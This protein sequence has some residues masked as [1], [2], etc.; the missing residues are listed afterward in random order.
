M[1]PIL[2]AILLVPAV[3]GEVCA[4]T[5]PPASAVASSERLGVLEVAGNSAQT[6]LGKPVHFEVQ[7]LRVLGDWAFLHARM[8]G[9]NGQPISYAGTRYEDASRHGQKSANYDALLQRKQGQW[10][11]QAEAIGATDVPW[12]DWS[13]RYGA[14][15]SL[16][17]EGSGN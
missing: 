9:P 15:S 2:L 8:Q 5:A 6:Q 16:F 3:T 1:R 7:R 4:Q 12:T 11:V 10:S 14:P 13:H 17:D